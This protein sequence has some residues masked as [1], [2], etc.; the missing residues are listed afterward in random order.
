MELTE[1]KPKVSVCVVTYNQEKYI[2]QCLQ[3][4]VDQETVFNFEIIVGDDCSTDG[5]REIIKEF[6]EQYPSV[7]KLILHEKNIGPQMNY[8]AVHNQAVGEFI[9]HMDGDDYALPGKLQEQASYL[10]KYPECNIVWHR[11]LIKNESTGVIAEDL[12]DLTKL[13]KGGFRRADILRFITVGLNSSKMYRA[14]VRHFEVPEFTTVDYFAN[15]EQVGL[16]YAHFAGDRPLGTYRAGIGIATSGNTTKVIL[17]ESFLYFA[18][19]YPQYKREIAFAVLVLFLAALKNRKWAN[20]LLFTEVLVC[21]FR[22]GSVLDIWR[23]K[24]ILAMLR[25]P[26]SVRRGGR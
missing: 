4:L 2:K 5:T 12:I 26:T 16:G 13:P 6:S 10:D 17:K 1:K 20:C 14:T 15:V 11:M 3:S 7:V 9:A 21:T 8:F 22:F 23:Y 19:K 18:I 24:H 25:N